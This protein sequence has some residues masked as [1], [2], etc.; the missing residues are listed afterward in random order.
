[1]HDVEEQIIDEPISIVERRKE[2]FNPFPGLRPFSIKEN[3]LFFGREGQSEEVIKNLT[4][5][6]FAAITGAS[7]GG[8]SSLIYCGVIPGLHGGFIPKAGSNWRIVPFRPGSDPMQNMA[9]AI[10]NTEKKYRKPEDDIYKAILLSVL[11]RSNQG[12]VDA[13]RQL[14]VPGDE[15]ILLIVDQFEELF[16]FRDATKDIDD[17]NETESFIKLLVE[18]VNQSEIPIYVVITMRSDFMGECSNFI[19]LSKKINES[20]YLIPQMSREDYRKAITG[21][22]AVAGA[23]IDEQLVNELLNSVQDESDTLSVI[24]HAMMRTYDHWSNYS[25]PNAPISYIDYEAAGK[26]DN[27]LSLHANEAFNE[28]SDTGKRICRSMFTTLTER[29]DD[30]R[31]IR[32]PAKVSTIAEIA[33]ASVK[34]TMEVI[35]KF[36]S[37]GRAFLTPSTDTELTPDTVIDISHESIMRIWDKLRIWVQEETESVQMYLRLAEAAELYQLGKTGLWRPPD[38]LLALNWKKKYKPNLAWARRYNPA[39]ERTM[40]FLEASEKRYNAEERNKVKVQKRVLRRTRRLAVSAVFIALIF[41]SMMFYANVQKREAEKQRLMAE[42]NRRQA[43]TNAQLAEQRAEEAEMYR[44]LAEQAAV[45]EEDKRKLAEIEREQAEL[46]RLI[47]MQEATEAEQQSEILMQDNTE[48]REEKET[49]ERTLQQTEEEKTMAQR[50]KEEALQ[51]RMLTIARTMAVKSSQISQNQDLKGLLA[52]QAY[53]F[54]NQYNGMEHNQDIYMG[55]YNALKSSNYKLYQGFQGHTGAVRSLAF[56]PRTNNFYSAGGDGKV[57]KWSLNGN[58]MRPTTLVNNN[59]INRVLAI[60]PTGNWLACGTGNSDIQLFNLNSE[61]SN[62]RIL[63]GHTGWVWSLSFTP[64]GNKLVSTSSDKTILVWDLNSFT[65]TKIVDNDQRIRVI[66]VSPNGEKIAGGADDGKIITWNMD[67]SNRQIFFNGSGNTVYALTYN[68]NGRYLAAGDKTG[69]LR[70][71]NAS[72]GGLVYNLSGHRARILDVNFSPDN[73][74]MASSSMD[75]TVRIWDMD[76]LNQSPVV[77]TGHES[78]VLAV[79]FSPDSKHLITSSQKGDLILAWP[80]EPDVMANEMCSV[81]SRNLTES[82]W[83]AYV[84]PDIPY[85]QTCKK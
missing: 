5:Y 20:N 66:A 26:V 75:G 35:E 82:E 40:V 77:L 6:R 52:Y 62:P 60:S 15:N 2:V 80:T 81:L 64:G 55:M 43:A 50:E 84:A 16:R 17:I 59:S 25:D 63:K 44:E 30:N 1:M 3:Y 76:N 67:G 54:N 28:L 9:R 72:S 42:E 69:R 19:E 23:N 46:Q 58:N 70:I 51:Q 21:P 34:D 7:G 47:A 56:H 41:F 22:I 38:L 12:L 33:Q 73:Q 18:A 83:N 85:Q 57:L 45:S 39:F 36:R 53:Q 13:Y 29:G 65:S 27:A 8:K 10:Y 11:R 4:K 74:F 68:S 37:K 79:A 32:H 78:W 24:Q 48:I 14:K 31:G 49:I 61:S 71:F